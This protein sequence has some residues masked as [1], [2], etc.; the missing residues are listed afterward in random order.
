MGFRKAAADEQAV[1]MG[2]VAV[3][4]GVEGD[5]FDAGHAEGLDI[6]GVIE[7]ES[8]ILGDG[9]TEVHARCR[10][11]R[12]RARG[13]L[14][15]LGRAGD[16]EQEIEV[17]L[18]FHRVGGRRQLGFGMAPFV[19]RDKAEMTF[20]DAQLGIAPDGPEDRDVG[21]A[22]DGG[23]QLG[24]VAVIGD[25]VEDDA[26]D[27]QIGVEGLVA[28]Q[29]RRDAA[30]H[31][32]A[33]DDQNDRR[34][35]ELGHGGVAVAALDV[36]SVEQA[37]VALD[38]RDVAVGAAAREQGADLVIGLGV[39]I[40][41]EAG[42]AGGRGKPHG[43]DVVR[44]LLEGLRRQTTAAQGGAE[45]ERYGRLARGFVG[46]RNEE[47]G[48]GGSESGGLP[49]HSRYER[50]GSCSTRPFADSVDIVTED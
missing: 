4:Q 44:P 21:E 3:G 14:W 40:E 11:S 25:V 33:V 23:P 29:Q 38:D 30:R 34:S 13:Q 22:L 5:Q 39:E 16:G 8:R 20:G 42:P 2:Q 17:D 24:F 27:R 43:V 28:D 48:H 6:V 49:Y 26:T 9:D 7:P 45:A 19:G 37:V 41:V 1:D 47:V 35:E 18:L 10:R 12:F 46:C 36:G 50:P 15:E 32:G 31:P